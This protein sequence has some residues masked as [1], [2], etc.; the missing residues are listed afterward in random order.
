MEKQIE[1]LDKFLDMNLN[2]NKYYRKLDESSQSY[3]RQ[4]LR[5]AL[6]TSPS[7][8][9]SQIVISIASIPFLGHE[10]LLGSFVCCSTDYPEDE[11]ILILRDRIRGLD[12]PTTLREQ[13]LNISES[14]R[15]VVNEDLQKVFYNWIG[16]YNKKNKEAKIKIA[17]EVYLMM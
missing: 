17:D 10:N 14:Q 3:L 1:F 15:K 8:N 7:Y 12:F 4:L 13:A 5:T 9:T 2:D 6:Y 11:A 16:N